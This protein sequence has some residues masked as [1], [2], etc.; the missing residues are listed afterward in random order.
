MRR[1]SIFSYLL[2]LLM[3]LLGTL[4]A[5]VSVK[6]LTCEYR[7]NPVGL[8]IQKPRLSW[9][10]VS[11]K[12][13]VT[14]TAYEIHVATS[15]KELKHKSALWWSS[16]KV[17]SNQSILVPYT[18][19]QLKTGQRVYWMVRVW[20]NKGKS[21]KW[22]APAYWE[23]GLIGPTAWDNASWIS[24]AEKGEVTTS[25]PAPYYR[26]E[27]N[28]Q[29][30]VAKA[31]VYVTALGTYQLYLNGKKVSKDLFSPGWTS[32]NKGIQYQVYDVSAQLMTHN[33]IG[34]IVG[35][36]WYRGRLGWAKGRSLYGNRLGLLMQVR[37]QYV[38]GTEEVI[39][40][41]TSWKYAYG[42]IL[43][44]DIYDGECYD[45]N[46]EMPGWDQANYTG[47]TWKP[48][49]LLTH[50]KAHLFATVS[51]MPQANKELKA[52]RIWVTPKGEQVA[53]LGQNMVGWVRLKVKGMP[54][55]TV[56]LTFAEV[57]DKAGN[58]Y[59]A[60]LRSA[61]STDTFILGDK[62]EYL[63]EPHFTFHGF[64]YVRFEGLKELPKAQDITGVVIHTPMKQSGYFTC[65]DTLVNQLQHNI[66]WGQRGNFLDVPTDCPQ[67]DERLGWT[68]DA[69]V[70][71]MTA[72][73]NFDV[74]N[75]YTK[76]LKDLA[77]D[78]FADG[79]IPHV[80]PDVLGNG[81]ST[82]WADASIL[83]PWTVYR[84]YGDKRILSSQY[85]S[86][87]KWVEY[88][89]K[90]A[91]DNYL[92]EGDP[93]FGD[94]LAYASSASDYTGATTEKDLIATAYFA[95][96]STLLGKIATV[97]DK[98][99]DAERWGTLSTH[100]KKAFVQEFVTPNGRLVS[101]TQ[102]AYAVALSFNLLPEYLIE[103]AAHYLAADVEK[104]KHLTTGFV[105]TPLLCP[106]LSDMGRDDL[107]FMLLMRQE[108]P[109]WLYPVTQGATTI[110]ER[111]DGQKPDGS[112]QTTEMN[113]FNHYAYGAIGGW[114]YNYIAGI[115]DNEAYP[116]Y[117]E[118]L[119]DPH[120]GGG[121]TS[122]EGH[123]ETMY[124]RIES[125]WELKDSTFYY[126]V[127]IPVNTSA[128]VMLP[129]ASFN[130]VMLNNEL[131][132]NSA[133]LKDFQNGSETIFKLGSG[134]YDFIYLYK[135]DKDK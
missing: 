100:V 121:L 21:S 45:F 73:Y 71:S 46:Q 87:K 25:L 7:T 76:W 13:N 54:G 125:R 99:E 68:G 115:A 62:G 1:K 104:F 82:A 108:Y 77:L 34:A 107:A 3:G 63:C 111:W 103:P 134:S 2:L 133:K 57:L 113:S 67:R 50:S 118:F 33:A 130:E 94:W 29:K 101:H 38:D 79:S 37:L 17:K 35:D 49:E 96:S 66:E 43:S 80:I 120:V 119:L 106:I 92:W 42:P 31:Q 91:G 23:A 24:V 41:D 65:S 97:L 48:V 123:L 14:Q 60:N 44:S 6:D 126:H 8:D 117:K 53:D 12:N 4:Q 16:D 10:L 95:Y 127:E 26:K 114:M 128:Q 55:D 9:K 47:G 85:E 81:G 112:F 19:P 74:A 122:A 18:G 86:M 124:G 93:H 64:R 78:Q 58:F 72:T 32:Y 109:S 61:K 30:K 116:G 129:H 102:T 15:I 5:Q 70:F 56:K 11:E 69:Q 88:M 51:A 89:E 83:V 40:T 75:F 52:D 131:L 98:P 110:W 84:A 27:F 20:D 132:I 135:S 39:T 59:T 90:R 36:G 105:G 22:S 28:L